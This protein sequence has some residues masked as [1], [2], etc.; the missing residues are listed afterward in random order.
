MAGGAWHMAATFEQSLHAYRLIRAQLARVTFQTRLRSTHVLLLH[1][2]EHHRA[3]DPTP[4]PTVRFTPPLPATDTATGSRAVPLL[5]SSSREPAGGENQ[6]LMHSQLAGLDGRHQ[7][8]RVSV[9]RWQRHRNC[10]SSRAS[11]SVYQGADRQTC[12]H[13]VTHGAYRHVA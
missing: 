6:R 7:S 13:A 5:A 12:H 2:G 4:A 3:Q 1:S 11:V 9:G 10:D 8:P